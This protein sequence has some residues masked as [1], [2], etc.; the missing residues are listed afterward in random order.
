MAEN[1]STQRPIINGFEP[2]D[3]GD[4]ECSMNIAFEG[5]EAMGAIFKTIAR[6]TDDKEIKALCSHAALIAELQSNDLDA[7]RERA[8]KAGLVAEARHE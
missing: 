7:L 3:I 6:L 5:A 1:I 4:I 8:M 2:V